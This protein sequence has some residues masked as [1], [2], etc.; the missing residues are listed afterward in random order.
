M[1]SRKATKKSRRLRKTRGRGRRRTQRGGLCKGGIDVQQ[2]CNEINTAKDIKTATTLYRKAALMCHPD[3]EGGNEEDFKTLQNCFQKKKESLEVPQ[4]ANAAPSP[5]PAQQPR[6]VPSSGPQP[7]LQ[8][9]SPFSYIELTIPPDIWKKIWDPST[10]QVKQSIR[11][12]LK[13]EFETSYDDYYYKLGYIRETSFRLKSGGQVK[14]LPL[15]GEGKVFIMV[16]KPDNL[17]PVIFK[18]WRAEVREMYDQL[19][20][21]SQEETS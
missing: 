2:V 4:P 8:R 20:A 5:A 15:D 17:L 19:I 1:P 7:T 21:A 11:D 9:S 10:Y 16:Q 18:Q 14:V 12:R 6:S 13:E 3:H